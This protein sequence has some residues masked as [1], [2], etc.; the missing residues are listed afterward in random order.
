MFAC[1]KWFKTAN[2]GACTANF[3]KMNI[4]GRLR[5]H[6]NLSNNV[7]GDCQSLSL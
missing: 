7:F 3:I 4:T 2:G 5:K 1:T 6:G